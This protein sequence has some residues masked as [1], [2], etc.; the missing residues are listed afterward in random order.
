MERQDTILIHVGHVM[1]SPESGT[2]YHISRALSRYFQ[3]VYINPI[4]GYGRWNRWRRA[5]CHR[6]NLCEG[7]RV[8]TP[9]APGGLRFLPRSMRALP[10]RLLIRTQFAS[11]WRQVRGQTVVLLS[12][13]SHLTPELH[14]LVQ[15]RLT[16]YHRLDDFGAMS[17]RHMQT[18]LALERISDLIFVVS[19]HLI[20]QHRSRGRDAILLPNGVAADLFAA[21]LSPETQIPADLLKIPEPRIGFIGWLA[22]KWI[23]ID[24]LYGVASHNPQWQFVLIGMRSREVKKQLPPNMHWLGPRP[25]RQLPQYLKGLDVCLVPFKQNAITMGAS[26]LKLY[27]YLAAGRA[28][29]STYVPDVQYFGDLVWQANTPREFGQAI[30]DALLAAHDPVQQRRRIEA[31]QPHTWETRAAQV[32]EC[33]QAHLAQREVK[34]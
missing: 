17:H 32:Y 13:L 22:P 1:F 9:L 7:V 33:I 18:E 25:Y 3:V 21:A 5:T 27:E 6:N 23:D 16:C 19:P 4:T 28:V 26:P 24:L 8:I 11:L 29:V 31:I 34:R 20:A 12:T 10:T 14:A 2:P 30:G 15:P